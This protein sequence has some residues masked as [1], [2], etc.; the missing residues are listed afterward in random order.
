MKMLMQLWRP[1]FELNGI[2]AGN[3]YDYLPYVIHYE[4]DLPFWYWLT[5]VVLEKRPLNGNSSSS[6]MR[7]ILYSSCVRSS[8]LHRSETWPVGKE[9]EVALQQ[10][11][12]RVVRWMCNVNVKDRVPSKD[13]R[14]RLGIDDRAAVKPQFADNSLVLTTCSYCIIFNLFTSREA[15]CV[16]LTDVCR[17]W[18]HIS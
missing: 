10:A 6:S 1:E 18:L 4:R 17:M 7:G 2:N 11:E 9:N 15:Y 5:Q 12:M 3:L 14:E 16:Y 13:L 8:M